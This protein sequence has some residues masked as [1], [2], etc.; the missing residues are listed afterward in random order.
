MSTVQMVVS[1]RFAGLKKPP[2]P[3]SPEKVVE[4]GVEGAAVSKAKLQN[5]VEAVS[6]SIVKLPLAPELA[7]RL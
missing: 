5:G 1:V 3:Q 4:P 7:P 6:S 2:L